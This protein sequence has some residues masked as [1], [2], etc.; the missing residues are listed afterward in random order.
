M[1]TKKYVRKVLGEKPIYSLTLVIS[2]I[3]A[4]VILFRLS[5]KYYQGHPLKPRENDIKENTIVL[6]RIKEVK[7]TVT[8]I[9]F[10]S[11]AQSKKAKNEN[12]RVILISDSLVDGEFQRVITEVDSLARQGYFTDLDY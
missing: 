5:G 3:S 10:Q 1:P 11:R 4:L 7:D 9:R 2:I 12:I 8:V 6:E